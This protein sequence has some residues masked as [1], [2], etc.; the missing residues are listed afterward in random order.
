MALLSLNGS[1]MNAPK[2]ASSPVLKDLSGDE[3]DRHTMDRGNVVSD[4]S[5]ISRITV[6]FVRMKLLEILPAYVIVED[7]GQLGEKGECQDS[8]SPK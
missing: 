4:S 1:G 2:T 3:E 8:F 6:W 7:D 5:R